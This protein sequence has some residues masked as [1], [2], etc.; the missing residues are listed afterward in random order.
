MSELTIDVT[1]LQDLSKDLRRLSP[2][3]QKG[4]LKQL[5]ATGEVVAREARSNA[6]FSTRIPASVK[7]RRRGVQVRVQ[8]G[9]AKA[10][11]AAA[12]EHGGL[13]GQFRHPVFGNRAVWVDQAAHPFLEPALHSA[14][15]PLEL[16]IIRAVDDAFHRAGFRG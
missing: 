14:I 15:V 9:G 5:G 7:V 11:H 10:P 2:S 16:G 4:F 1:E 8:A 6:G 13:A 3:L 12:L